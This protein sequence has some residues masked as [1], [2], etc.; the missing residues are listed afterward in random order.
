[1]FRKL[2]QNLAIYSSLFIALAANLPRITFLKEDGIMAR[3]IGNLSFPE[4]IFQILINGLF[5]FYFFRLLIT[6]LTKPLF[7][8]LC[9]SIIFFVISVFISTIIQF[10]GFGKLREQYRYILAGCTV[11]YL[12]SMLFGVFMV[13]ITD[14]L[15]TIR[16]KE[17]E[18]EQL[19]NRYLHAELNL[20][21]QQINPHFLFNS[22]S[23]LS[24]II[25]ENPQKAQLFIGQMAKYFRYTLNSYEKQL[26]YLQIE[27]DEV[28]PYID[29][30]SMRFE[31]GLQVEWA[32]RDED[33]QQMLPHLSLQPLLENAVKHNLSYI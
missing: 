10:F 20:L 28:Q 15:K 22:F 24:G 23:T 4:L 21:K 30:L 5:C 12:V 29:L 14:L 31:H 32:I 19:N 3:H 6:Y 33:R 18:N 27:I 16:R 1:M 26:V 25:V 8:I 17:L 9:F 13:K 11:R 2:E 7:K